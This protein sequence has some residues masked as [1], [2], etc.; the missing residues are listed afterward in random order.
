MDAIYL[1]KRKLGLQHLLYIVK[2]LLTW[3]I[4]ILVYFHFEIK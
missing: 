4:R 1:V 2:Q 3:S